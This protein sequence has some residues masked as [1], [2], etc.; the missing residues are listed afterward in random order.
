[1][2]QLARVDNAR[3]AF[4]CYHGIVRKDNFIDP[5]FKYLMGKY[6]MKES[7]PKFA[8]FG[9]TCATDIDRLSRITGTPTLQ[10][11]DGFGNRIEHIAFPEDYHKT[12]R[13]AYASEIL[14]LYKSGKHTDATSSL[15][16]HY[17]LSH[18]GEAGHACPITCT[19]G[20]SRCIENELKISPSESKAKTLKYWLSKIY[21]SNYDEHYHG[22]QFMTEVQGGSDVGANVLTAVPVEE[23]DSVFTHKLHGEKW[24]CSAVDAHLWLVVARPENSKD[25]TPGLRGFIVP[26]HLDDDPLK[27]NY[28]AIRRLK[29]KLGTRSMASAELDFNGALAMQL[30]GTFKDI[31]SLVIDTSRVYNALG[32]AGMIN[33]S[34][35]EARAY[36]HTRQA[37]GTPIIN[38]P[39]IKE[40]VS[41]LNVAAHA[42]RSVGFFVA[43]LDVTTITKTEHNARRML[44]N[45]NKYWA[46]HDSIACAHQA[47]D[48]LGGNGAIEE[49][50]VLPRLLRDSVVYAQWEGP[51]NTLC[52]QVLR[53]CQRIGLHKDLFSLLLKVNKSRDSSL[54]KTTAALWDRLVTLPEG[55]A[56]LVVRS[57]VDHLAYVVQITLML[58]ED[59]PS[60]LAAAEHLS[61]RIPNVES[62]FD[63]CLNAPACDSLSKL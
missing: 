21:N 40:Q 26:R 45:L 1:M 29:D 2:S 9:K 6:G 22:S 23:S 62:D 44:V 11:F 56:S 47:I 37:F 34:F 25:G 7:L 52:A 24:F 8:K 16:L 48:I 38:F 10:R 43:S 61:K 14:S 30:T 5:H 46:A 13:L 33:R 50:S 53:D 57:L 3:Q 15:A 59:H 51:H 54:I 19:V 55:A 18:C 20:L 32:D 4:N 42:S 27:P 60:S 49:F 31:L 12:G 41:R 36:A 39:L 28:Y 35:L 58:D 17:I 63:R